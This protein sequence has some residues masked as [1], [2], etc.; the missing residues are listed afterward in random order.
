LYNTDILVLCCSK[1]I[2]TSKAASELLRP[3]WAPQFKKDVDLLEQVQLKAIRMING[4]EHLPQEEMLGALQL[5][6]LEKRRVG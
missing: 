5:L 1:E 4:L 6:S 2:G 3:V